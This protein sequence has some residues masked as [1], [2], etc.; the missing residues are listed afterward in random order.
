MK[1]NKTLILAALAAFSIGSGF[2]G[3][4]IFVG[5]S[6]LAPRKPEQ[7]SGSWGDSM[8][9]KLADGWTICNCAIGGRTV[10]TIQ[11]KK[12]AG[13]EKAVDAM[14]KGDF[15]IVQF[16]INDANKKKLVEIP[17]FKAEMGKFAD[18]IREK[19]ATPVFCSPITAGRYDKKGKYA[20]TPSRLAYGN[21]TKEIAAEKKVEFIDMTALTG[22]ILRPLSKEAGQDLYVGKS[23]KDGK[24]IFDT[25]HP[26]KKG[27]SAYGDAF[28]KDAKTRK[29]SIASIFK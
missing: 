3:N 8:V 9:D 24:E 1:A 16:G 20:D 18:V 13:W 25:T 17:A 21:A 15:V 6:T 2:A 12:K 28:I 27:A 4:L 29:L 14:K 10:K 26:S 23:T 22:D 7:R 19:G 5:D 11:G